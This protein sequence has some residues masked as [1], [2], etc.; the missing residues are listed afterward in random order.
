MFGNEKGRKASAH[1]KT[2]LLL[3]RKISALFIL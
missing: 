2:I 3:N 1:L